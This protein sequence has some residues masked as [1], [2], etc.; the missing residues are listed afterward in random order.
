[1]TGRLL[2]EDVEQAVIHAQAAHDLA[3]RVASVREALAIATYKAGNYKTA[4]REARTVRRLTG[5]DEWLPMIADCERGLGRPERALDLL[6]SETLA[7]LPE[8]TRAECLIVASGAR[9]DLGDLDASVAVLDVDLLRTRVR[10]PWAARMRLA[11]AEALAR[12]GE[13]DEAARWSKLAVATDPDV[14]SDP[15]LREAELAEL[16]IVDLAEDESDAEA[17]SQAT[18]DVLA[19]APV[20]PAADAPEQGSV[21]GAGQAATGAEESQDQG[22]GRTYLKPDAVSDSGDSDFSI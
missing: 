19:D 6:D 4:L 7:S 10:S 12:V 5:N 18:E 2:D 21:Q 13:E 9:A 8:G 22:P 11:Y 17:T 1:M 14:V 3:P 16:E 20:E 15:A